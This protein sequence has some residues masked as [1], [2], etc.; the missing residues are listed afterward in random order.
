M[1]EFVFSNFFLIFL[2][3]IKIY[4][5]ERLQRHNSKSVNVHTDY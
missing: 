5:L 4:L 2:A 1:I 3:V